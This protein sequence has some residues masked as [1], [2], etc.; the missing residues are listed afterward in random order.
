MVLDRQL[1]FT[2]TDLNF[3]NYQPPRVSAVPPPVD[4][5]KSPVVARRPFP[6]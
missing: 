5:S 1:T 3:G 2:D 4:N 6:E